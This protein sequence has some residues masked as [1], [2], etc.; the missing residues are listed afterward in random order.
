MNS[1]R[2]VIVFVLDMAF[3]LLALN[4]LAIVFG[5]LANPLAGVGHGHWTA[6]GFAVVMAL[7][8]RTLIWLLPLTALVFLIGSLI[9]REHSNPDHSQ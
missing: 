8:L 1:V 5:F 4:A 2:R 9:S 6:T 7:A 3:V